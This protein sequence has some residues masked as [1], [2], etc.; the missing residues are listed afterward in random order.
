M[1]YPNCHK[2]HA[3]T[4]LV[5]ETAALFHRKCKRTS[6]NQEQHWRQNLDTSNHPPCPTVQRHSNTANHII[7]KTFNKQDSRIKRDVLTRFE[8][9]NSV[10]AGKVERRTWQTACFSHHRKVRPVVC[11][12]TPKTR[13]VATKCRQACDRNQKLMN[14]RNF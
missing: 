7:N 14:S 6:P 13:Q 8:W 2:R 9:D 11:I 3:P 5:A 1:L 10:C 12:H 4:A